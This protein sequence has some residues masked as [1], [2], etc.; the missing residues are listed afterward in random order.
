[1][2]PTVPARPS[3]SLESQEVNGGDDRGRGHRQGSS[4]Y[5]G[6]V[7][8]RQ[9]HQQSSS[10]AT[11]EAVSGPSSHAY[12]PSAPPASLSNG[13]VSPSSSCPAPLISDER[14]ARSSAFPEISMLS[15]E[16]AALALAS[17]PPPLPTVLGRTG[18]EETFLL[19]N[20]VMNDFDT[21]AFFSDHLGDV[22]SHASSLRPSGTGGFFRRW[23]KPASVFGSVRN[24][25]AEMT[26]QSPSD[27]LG[28]RGS[29][30]TSEEHAEMQRLDAPQSQLSTQR[31]AGNPASGGPR[32]VS[33]GT[34]AASSPPPQTRAA[35]TD[36][37]GAAAFS[38]SAPTTG[39]PA[40]SPASYLPPPPS[41]PKPAEARPTQEG[42][43]GSSPSPFSSAPLAGASE[44]VGRPSSSEDSSQD[45]SEEDV[46]E[47]DQEEYAGSPTDAPMSSG[48]TS[49]LWKRLG[50]QRLSS[51]STQGRT[52]GASTVGR[53][54]L[55]VRPRRRRRRY[56]PMTGVPSGEREEEENPVSFSESFSPAPAREVAVLGAP[57]LMQATEDGELETG[58][59]AT[60]RDP[61][62]AASPPRWRWRSGFLLS[63]QS[64][65]ATRPQGPAGDIEMGRLPATGEGDGPETDFQ[66]PR[67]EREGVAG[68]GGGTWRSTVGELGERIRVQSSAVLASLRGAVGR[69]RRERDDQQ[70]ATGGPAP[71]TTDRTATTRAD[72]DDEDDPSC[73]QLLLVTGCLCWFPLLW[74]VG[75]MLWCVTPKEHR[76]ARAWGSINV[77]L[78]FFTFLYLFS[79]VWNVVKPVGQRAV[80]FN[81]EAQLGL[82]AP[83]PPR[84]PGN[85]WKVEDDGSGVEHAN[86]LA[87]TFSD[88]VDEAWT[89]FS[90]PRSSVTQEDAKP[91]LY[92]RV[93]R[94]SAA[95]PFDLIETPSDKQRPSLL[96]SATGTWVLGPKALPLPAGNHPPTVMLGPP[97]I[98]SG[99]VLCSI[100]F[101]AGDAPASS[102][103][104]SLRHIFAREREGKRPQDAAAEGHWLSSRSRQKLPLYDGSGGVIAGRGDRQGEAR[105]SSRR[106][107]HELHAV[108]PREMTVEDLLLGDK[109]LP[110][111]FFGAGLRCV[112]LRRYLSS[113]HASTGVGGMSR[114]MQKNAFSPDTRS[115][116]SS[117]RLP[118]RW[119]LLHRAER[120]GDVRVASQVIDFGESKFLCNPA[121][122]AMGEEGSSRDAEGK[123]GDAEE[124]RAFRGFIDVQQVLLR[125]LP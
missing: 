121:V 31:S 32:L 70:E 78:V 56:V 93:V 99:R 17:M 77:F 79:H 123:E 85:L 24:S 15:A 23:W 59:E 75:A 118:F 107:A 115:S 94:S 69:L 35:R 33:G 38:S 95:S 103:L 109:N 9:S 104:S 2:A 80:L 22:A 97:V 120:G 28:D 14:A 4:L 13:A 36:S 30:G 88:P 42:H 57:A 114:P 20:E 74:V 86:R 37:G 62:Q 53:R 10:V 60:A 110:S 50:L 43:S 64:P 66:A 41:A 122:V 39:V 71:A 61:G 90:L 8:E 111:S 11:S 6:F 48:P 3:S 58:V 101:G 117:T 84:H 100:R 68:A 29:S 18:E 49:W 63:S 81:T 7:R 5:S 16:D 46:L 102:A 55:G 26:A 119:L 67:P 45:L 21:R 113:S 51:S 40:G 87:W 34:A 83:F 125:A 89:F 106:K 1:M 73:H 91:I 65:S 92:G 54:A 116:S 112:S 25:A 124:S 27:P 72:E 98:A 47:D 82:E 96:G 12:A 44:I 76:R 108:F 52:P 19:E 105:L